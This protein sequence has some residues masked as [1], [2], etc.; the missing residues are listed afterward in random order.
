MFSF[1]TFRSFIM[2]SSCSAFGCKNRKIPSRPDLKFHSFPKDPQRRAKW[3]QAVKRENFIPNW[4]TK[5]CSD[6]FLPSD[7]KGESINRY[8]NLTR[9]LLK[10]EAVPSVFLKKSRKCDQCN[11]E[12]IYV[13]HLKEHFDTIHGMRKDFS[14][15]KCPYISDKKSN[16]DNW[17]DLEKHKETV[18]EIESKPKQEKIKISVKTEAQLDI[19]KKNAALLKTSVY[20]SPVPSS[21]T[22]PSTMQTDESRN[23]QPELC[24]GPTLSKLVFQSKEKNMVIHLPLQPIKK[25]E[26]TKSDSGSYVNLS[27][28]NGIDNHFNKEAPSN[29]DAH[30][31]TSQPITENGIMVEEELDT[32]I[33]TEEEEDQPMKGEVTKSESSPYNN[34]SSD[35]GIGRHLNKEAAPNVDAHLEASQPISENGII[36]EQKL[37]TGI[38]TEEEAHETGTD[39]KPVNVAEARAAIECLNHFFLENYLDDDLNEDDLK[40]HFQYKTIVMAKI[41]QK[42][43]QQ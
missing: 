34:H 9:S 37:D 2:V 30:F 17:R 18:H 35:N 13:N 10:E 28:D 29:V 33:K 1:C 25:D 38:K 32:E 8:S 42:L 5:I 31:E 6:H 43:I 23:T 16:I 41:N 39:R 12:T 21:I 27:S 24:D 7:Y 20:G 4:S 19:L 40:V 15:G 36:V 14:C 22:L 3:I 26:I 11:F